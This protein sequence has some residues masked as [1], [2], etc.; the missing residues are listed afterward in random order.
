MITIQPNQKSMS[1]DE[2]V[3]W[4]SEDDLPY[5]IIHKDADVAFLWGPT[6]DSKSVNDQYHLYIIS[7][8]ENEEVPNCAF[9]IDETKTSEG[10]IEEMKED[11]YPPF[12][13]WEDLEIKRKW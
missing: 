13:E 6:A 7:L 1:L 12:L 8:D 10:E 9:N 11:F 5:Y 4:Y 3:K 2:F